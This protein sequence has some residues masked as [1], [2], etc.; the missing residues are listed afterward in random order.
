MEILKILCGSYIGFLISMGGL[1]VSLALN[2]V[3]W[4]VLSSI[5]AVVSFAILMR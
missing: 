5:L 1:K 2:N 4:Y 3:L